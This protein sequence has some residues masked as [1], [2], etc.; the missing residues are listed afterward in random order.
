MSNNECIALNNGFIWK[1]NMLLFIWIWKHRWLARNSSHTRSI[2][3]HASAAVP[4]LVVSN[5]VISSP[6]YRLLPIY[7][8]TPWHQ[9]LGGCLSS[10]NHIPSCISCL[11]FV[12]NHACL[13]LNNWTNIITIVLFDEAIELALFLSWHVESLSSFIDN[14]VDLCVGIR[15]ILL[16]FLDL[17]PHIIFIVA[18]CFAFWIQDILIMKLVKDIVWDH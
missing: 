16:L 6:E 13:K 12:L 4:V 18:I 1:G 8:H 5:L 3:R 17:Y 2:R 7:C 11:L 15:S 10:S 9:A 14:L